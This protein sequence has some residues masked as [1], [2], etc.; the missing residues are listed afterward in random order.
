VGGWDRGEIQG[1]M[2]AKKLR[3]KEVDDKDGIFHFE[4]GNRGPRV[5]MV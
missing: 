3:I 4:G 5:W 1:E 2:G